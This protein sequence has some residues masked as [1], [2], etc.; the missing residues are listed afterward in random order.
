MDPTFGQ[1]FL[2]RKVRELRTYILFLTKQLHQIIFL[3]LYHYFLTLIYFHR[4]RG[5]CVWNGVRVVWEMMIVMI[6][7][8]F[9]YWTVVIQ[10]LLR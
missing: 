8:R 6:L 7:L 9:I 3:I 4:L 1:S 5:F 2:V 10:L